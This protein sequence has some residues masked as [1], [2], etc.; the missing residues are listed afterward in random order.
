VIGEYSAYRVG[1]GHEK[2][3]KFQNFSTHLDEELSIFSVELLHDESKGSQLGRVPA[4][5]TLKMAHSVDA[6]REG[7]HCAATLRSK[8]CLDVRSQ[9]EAKG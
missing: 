5:S 1:G 2:W 6:V 7:R 8:E 9:R 4:Y 3:K